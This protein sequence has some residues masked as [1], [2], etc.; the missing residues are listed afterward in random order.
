MSEVDEIEARLRDPVNSWLNGNQRQDFARLLAI[1]KFGESSR[2]ALE[3]APDLDKAV[4][5]YDRAS[6]PPVMR[7]G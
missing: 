6:T 5:G 1:A 3:R 4:P 7:S 2:A